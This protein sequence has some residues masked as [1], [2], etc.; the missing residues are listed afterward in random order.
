MNI[1]KRNVEVQVFIVKNVELFGG[2][3]KCW[4]R[5]AAGEL[6]NL[7]RVVYLALHTKI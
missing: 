2:W 4:I 5:H 1:G 7:A 6:L 3:R